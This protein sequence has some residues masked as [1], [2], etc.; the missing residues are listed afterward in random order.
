[1]TK[2]LFVETI[3]FMKTRSDNER[4]INNYLTVEFE[5]AI[6]YPYSKYETQMIKVLEDIFQDESE[7]ITYFIYE[8]DF[9]RQWEPGTVMIDEKDIPLS[10]PEELYDMLADNLK[11]TIQELKKYN[12]ELNNQLAELEVDLINLKNIKKTIKNI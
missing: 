4:V 8:L 1:M 11:D 2:E 7:W 6:F 3:N 12:S 10:T 5:D 9:G